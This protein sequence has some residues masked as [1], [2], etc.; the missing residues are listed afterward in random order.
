MG[1]Q[2]AVTPIRGPASTASLAVMGNSLLDFVMALV[3]DPEVA[4]RYAADP[5][6]ALAAAGL[7]GVTTADV[8]SL[9]PMVTDSLATATPAFGAAPTAITDA[10]NVWASGAATA[11]FDAFGIT[12]PAPVVPTIS[13]A[14]SLESALPGGAETAAD[15][16]VFPAADMPPPPDGVLTPPAE[17]ADPTG[18]G[19]PA[20]GV[21]PAGH[22]PDAHPG[23]GAG[24]DL[25]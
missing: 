23:D 3:R 19:D 9:R 6:R 20:P 4:A 2:A 13:T 15:A 22:H 25:F 18:L 17:W 8:E 21:D 14:S 12:P 10:A 1:A 7:P 11:A 5:A 16:E 24:F